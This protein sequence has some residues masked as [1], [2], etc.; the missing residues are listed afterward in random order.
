MARMNPFGVNT[1]SAARDMVA[2]AKSMRQKR[3]LSN[4]TILIVLSFGSLVMIIPFLWMLVTSFDWEARLTIPFPPRTWPEQLTTLTYQ[5]AFLNIDMLRYIL[6]SGLVAFGVIVVSILSALLS[7]YALSKIRFKGSTFILLLA[8]STMMIPF[9][10][11]MIPQ[12]LLFDKLNLID[13]YW[14]FYLPAL[15][16]AFGTFLAK[17]FIDQLPIALR[18]AAIIDGAKERTVFWKIYFPLCIPIVATMVILQFLAV[19]NDLLWPLLVLNSP[20]KYTIQLGLAMFTYNQGINQLP[21][22][23]MAATAVSLVPV[24]AVYL[25]LQRYIVESI[26]QTGIK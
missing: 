14:A 6:N 2:P 8:L 5:M 17:Q 24:V 4:W 10:M 9:E 16:Y 11:T 25:A 7:G 15:N 22:I 20:E 23:I 12:Y 19:W 21:A 13:S 18:E 26:A 1:P 3:A